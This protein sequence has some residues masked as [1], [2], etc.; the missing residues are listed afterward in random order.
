MLWRCGEVRVQRST[1][2]GTVIGLWGIL[3]LSEIENGEIHSSR[4]HVQSQWR[5][6]GDVKAISSSNVV[7]V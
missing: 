5:S 1:L 4:W 7:P 2:V 3:L 6:E